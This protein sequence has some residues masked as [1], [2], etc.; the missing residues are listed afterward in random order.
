MRK[1][2]ATVVVLGL[3]W[4]GYTAWPLARHLR[5]VVSLVERLPGASFGSLIARTSTPGTMRPAA[6]HIWH[7]GCRRS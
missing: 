5:C 6:R 1:T 7:S 4:I 3:V 2:M